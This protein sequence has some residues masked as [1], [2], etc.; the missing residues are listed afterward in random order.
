MRI[1]D[2]MAAGL[3]VGSLLFAL[4]NHHARLKEAKREITEIRETLR[5]HNIRLN[6]LEQPELV[7]AFYTRQGR[8]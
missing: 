5:S 7:R 8:W 1:I 2:I 4:H 6:K 3:V